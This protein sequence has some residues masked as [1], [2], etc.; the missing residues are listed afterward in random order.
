MTVC[1]P[2]LTSL[3]RLLS[4]PSI[5]PAAVTRRLLPRFFPSPARYPSSTFASRHGGAVL[6]S[7]LSSPQTQIQT[8][9]SHSSA[10][11]ALINRMDQ[12][13]KHVEGLTL[14]AMT[15]K[16]PDCYPAINPNH[17]YRAHIADILAQITGVDAKIIFPNILWTTLEKGDFVLA[18]PSLRLKGKKFD[19]LAKEWAEK[20]RLHCPSPPLPRVN[21]SNCL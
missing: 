21:D 6:S 2:T 11:K 18:A 12:L 4:G 3:F 1:Q 7:L 13:A 8:R 10:S 16:Y 20:V 9:Q 14:D 5:R 19:E 17:L 15:E